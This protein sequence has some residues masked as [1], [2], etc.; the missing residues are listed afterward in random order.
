MTVDLR[1]SFLPVCGEPR[2]RFELVDERRESWFCMPALMVAAAARDTEEERGDGDG[3]WRRK[4]S[5]FAWKTRDWSGDPDGEREGGK[6]FRSGAIMADD[7][8][9]LNKGKNSL[10]YM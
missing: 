7:I 5:G 6:E 2:L 10:P 1:R 9:H 4:L 3:V 8:V